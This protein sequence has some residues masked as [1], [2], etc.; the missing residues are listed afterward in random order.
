[1][2]FKKIAGI[3]AKKWIAESVLKGVTKM[4]F[5]T[6]NRYKYNNFNDFTFTMNSK[7]GLTENPIHANVSKNDNTIKENID[8]MDIT[9]T[10]DEITKTA[11]QKQEK[12]NDNYI[13]INSPLSQQDIKYKQNQTDTDNAEEISL[14]NNKEAE[15]IKQLIEDNKLLQQ[16]NTTLQEQLIQ[17]KE[18]KKKVQSYAEHMKQ[19]LFNYKRRNK[20]E[21]EQKRI[22]IISSISKTIIPTID[23]FERIINYCLD[24][25]ERLQSVTDGCI[26]IYKKL[27][28]SLG[29]LGIE[30]IDPTGEEYDPMIAMA[31]SHEEVIGTKPNTVFITYQKGYKIGDKIIRSATVGVAK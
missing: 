11:Q 15:Q 3:M 17:V 9:D 6:H 8:Y 5:Q 16:Q 26:N 13:E 24:G 28:A 2:Y 25:G 1:M 7:Q 14:Q 31:M 22:E 12:D 10:I 18:E 30:Q 20:N 4:A 23:D 29:Q 27:L 19:D 21:Q